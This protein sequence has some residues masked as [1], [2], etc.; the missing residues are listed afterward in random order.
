[1]IVRHHIPPALSG[2]HQS[3]TPAGHSPFPSGGGIYSDD[4]VGRHC[5]IASEPDDKFDHDLPDQPCAVIIGLQLAAHPGF[6]TID[7]PMIFIPVIHDLEIAS[8]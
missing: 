5:P 1:M 3:V 2:S 8:A 6:G 4:G 7:I